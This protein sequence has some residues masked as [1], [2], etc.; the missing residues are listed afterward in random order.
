LRGHLGQLVPQHDVYDILTIFFD[1]FITKKSI[2]AYFASSGDFNCKSC[3]TGFKYSRAFHKSK[4]NKE[5]KNKTNEKH[6]RVE[7]EIKVTK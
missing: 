6:S 5:F 1:D 4:Q 3:F 7:C 2:F